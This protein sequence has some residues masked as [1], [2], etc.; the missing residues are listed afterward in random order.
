MFCTLYNGAG[1]DCWQMGASKDFGNCII[2][3]DIR[4]D[5]ISGMSDT[6]RGSIVEKADGSIKAF[7]FLQFIGVK[8]SG[9]GLKFLFL[10]FLIRRFKQPY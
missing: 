8:R 1:V 3:G 5:L 9:E 7:I 2:E 6:K 4:R 10:L